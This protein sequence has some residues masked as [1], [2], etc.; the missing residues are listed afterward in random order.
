MSSVILAFL[1]LA[2][3]G[4]CVAIVVSGTK[5]V[6][7]LAGLPA[8]MR[9]ALIDMQCDMDREIECFCEVGQTKT[10]EKQ[11]LDTKL[12]FLILVSPGGSGGV[13]ESLGRSG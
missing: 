4:T 3:Q 5:R 13:W 9:A 11:K 2:R 7:A 12:Q 1:L 10:N 8:R 6:I